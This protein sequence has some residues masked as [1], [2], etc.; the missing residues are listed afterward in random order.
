MIAIIVW[1]SFDGTF[2]GAV[3]ERRRGDRDCHCRDK[4]WEGEPCVAV[5]VVM[6]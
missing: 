6:T 3:G 2:R 5:F 1:L 4:P